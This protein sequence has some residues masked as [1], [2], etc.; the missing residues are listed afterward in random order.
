MDNRMDN[1]T[2]IPNWI[3]KQEQ[4]AILAFRCTEA[5]A[6]NDL[7]AAVAP[8]RNLSHPSNL[9]YD[10]VGSESESTS[11][12]EE[13]PANLAISGRANQTPSAEEKRSKRQGEN[14][15]YWKAITQLLANETDEVRHSIK[16]F[17]RN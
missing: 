14:S 9:L 11:S 2:L 4:N 15:L 5:N 7:T 12:T 17:S 10:E 6:W 8:S 13:S 1:L 16:L 3:S